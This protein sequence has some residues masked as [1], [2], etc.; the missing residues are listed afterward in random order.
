MH[1]SLQLMALQSVASRNEKD[2]M[3]VEPAASS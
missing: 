3:V 2:W 1:Y